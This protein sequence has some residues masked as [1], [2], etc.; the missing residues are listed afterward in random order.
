MEVKI[1]SKEQAKKLYDRPELIRGLLE[2]SF[3]KET[4][5]KQD[6][7]DFKTFADLCHAKG[8]TETEFE[9]RLNALPV[10]DQTKRFMRIELMTEVLNQGWVPN[11]FDT[12]EE[13]WYPW[14]RVSSSGLAFTYSYFICGHADASV[15]SCLCFVSEEVSNYSGTQFIKLWSEFISGKTL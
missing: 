11:T 3:G 7:R 6:F 9:A 15:G 5:K 1:D 4:F 8:T 2:E 12:N 14:F 13:K 10:S